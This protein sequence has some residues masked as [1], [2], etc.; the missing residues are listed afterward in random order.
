MHNGTPLWNRKKRHLI[1]ISYFIFCS[2]WGWVLLL[3]MKEFVSALR[4]VGGFLRLPPPIKLAATIYNV[5]EILLKVELNTINQ[6]N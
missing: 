6:P 4:Q 1:N 5:A 3:F 2:I